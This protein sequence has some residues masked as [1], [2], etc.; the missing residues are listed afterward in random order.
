MSNQ[1]IAET[2]CVTAYTVSKHVT[3][4]HRKLGVKSRGAAAANARQRG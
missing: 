4:I 3:G 2:L 1:E